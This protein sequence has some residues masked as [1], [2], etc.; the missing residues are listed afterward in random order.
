MPTAPFIHIWHGD[1]RR[2]LREIEASS[3]HLVL[4]DPPYFLD[5]LDET[6]TKGAAD[7]PRATGTVG[8]LPVGMKFDKSQGKRLESFMGQVASEV[9]RVL[10]PGAFFIC[11]S[12]PRLYHRMAV[13]I[14]EAGFEIRDMLIWH[15][16]GRA[17]FK[18]F[19]LKHFVKRLKCPEDEKRRI[20]MELGDR[21]T[22]QLRPQFEALVLAQKPREGRFLDNWLKYRVGLIDARK[23]LHGRAPSTVFPFEKP[24]RGRL[25]NHL[26]VK[27]VPLLVNLI[28]IFTCESQL[29]VD[30]FVGSGST[31]VAAKITGR[32]CIGIE[33]N[34]QYVK[35]ARRRLEEAKL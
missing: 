33:I 18:G 13:A 4:T 15:Y 9:R 16:T 7:A 5:G 14:E 3:V 20:L 22:P 17:Q 1:C 11:F 30:P 27:P 23:G 12:Q 6:W 2:K 8:G 24:R 34:E 26:A 32:S 19:S 29:V 31:A 25:L 10:A 35:M 28:E 21:K